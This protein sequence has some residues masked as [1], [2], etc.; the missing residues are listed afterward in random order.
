MS[1]PESGTYYVMVHAYDTAA[2]GTFNVLITGGG[3]GDPCEI[4]GA[5]MDQES[6]VIR[7]MPDSGADNDALCEWHIHCP[8]GAVSVTFTHLDTEADCKLA[9]P[10]SP[11]LWGL[12][13][14]CCRCRR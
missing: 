11:S 13:S 12:L 5:T 14:L 10:P 4:G 2:R 9:H 6:A 3:D 7:Y 8:S 1:C